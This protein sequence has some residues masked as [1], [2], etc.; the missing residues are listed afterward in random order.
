MVGQLYEQGDKRRDAG[1]TIF[2]MGINAGAFFGQIICASFAESPRWGWH[3]GFGAAGVGMLPGLITY[4][5]AQAEISRRHRRGRPTARRRPAQ[6]VTARL[7][8][9]EER[10]RLT[11]LLVL[12]AF[13]IIFWMAFEQASTSMNFFAQDRTDRKVGSFLVPAGWFQSINSGRPRDRGAAFRGAVDLA[14]PPES[15]AEHADEDGDRAGAGG[16]RLRV[17]GGRGAADSRRR[18]GQSLLAVRR[19]FVPHVRR[20]LPVADRAVVRHQGGAGTDGGAADGL[21]VL[22]HR[23]GRVPRGPV[24]GADRQDRARRD[25]PSVRRPGR[26]LPGAGGGAAVGGRPVVRG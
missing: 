8:T 15:R 7:L 4:L 6:H 26:F 17:H 3:W 21:L 23:A 14:R 10:D 13:T 19:V 25:L 18:A 24:R 22:R 11:A 12:F 9:R 16:P 2:Y 20:A 1:F 5:R